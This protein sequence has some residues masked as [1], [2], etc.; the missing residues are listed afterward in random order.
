MDEGLCVF[1]DFLVITIAD[2]QTTAAKKELLLKARYDALAASGGRLAVKKAI[3]KKQKK[4]SQKEKRSRP[5]S[6]SSGSRDG[7]NRESD[8]SRERIFGGGPPRKRQ[9]TRK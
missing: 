9:R 5:F 8:G 3:E 2:Y 4:Q 7:S 1:N 6:A